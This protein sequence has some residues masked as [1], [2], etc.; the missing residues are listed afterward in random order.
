M[1]IECEQCHTK[2]II[3]DEKIVKNVLR[4]TCQKCGHVITARVEEIPSGEQSGNTLGKWRATSLNTPKRTTIEA[5]AWYYS[6]NGESFGPFT[7]AELIARLQDPD[8][9]EIA[10]RCYIWC[11]T[12]EQWRPILEVEPFS[13][14][15]LMPPPPAPTPVA[16][17]DTI[18]SAQDNL[19]PLFEEKHTPRHCSITPTRPSSPNIQGLRQRLS[20]QSEETKAVSRQYSPFSKPAS[21]P[22]PRQDDVPTHQAIPALDA[23]TAFGH[24]VEEDSPEDRTQVGAPSPFFSFQSLDA[25]SPDIQTEIQPGRPGN[26]NKKPFPTVSSLPAITPKK[27]HGA[28]KNF[29]AFTAPSNPSPGIASIFSE[30]TPSDT[31]QS[32]P[33]IASILK[34]NAKETSPSTPS[35]PRFASLRSISHLSAPAIPASQP[36]PQDCPQNAPGK[37]THTS[38]DLIDFKEDIGDILEGE[39]HAPNAKRDDSVSSWL[40]SQSALQSASSDIDFSESD[41]KLPPDIIGQD[42]HNSDIALKPGNLDDEQSRH[43][44]ETADSHK[45]AP[46][47]PEQDAKDKAD[48]VLTNSKIPALQPIPATDDAHGNSKA[49]SGDDTSDLGDIDLDDTPSLTETGSIDAVN[50]DSPSEK[51]DA[52]GDIDLDDAPQAP[53]NDHSDKQPAVSSA[54]DVGNALD[55]ETQ[56]DAPELAR[57]SHAAPA[58]A[59]HRNALLAEI[60]AAGDMPEIQDESISEKSQLIQLNHFI[61]S[62]KKDKQKRNIRIIAI[63]MV[64]AIAIAVAVALKTQSD[65]QPPSVKPEITSALILQPR[66]RDITSDE[67]N[68]LMPEKD[69]EMID[70]SKKPR[71]PN[72]R[73]QDTAQN[74]ANSSNN[75]ESATGATDGSDGATASSRTKKDGRANVVLQQ[76]NDFADTNAVKGSQIQ[77]PGKSPSTRDRFAIGLR[78]VSMTVQECHRREAKNGG[79]IGVE[80]IYIQLTVNPD[81]SVSA[82]STDSRSNIPDSFAKCLESKKTRW[83]FAPFDGDP[84]NLKQGFVLN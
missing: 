3:P 83:K 13:S 50:L 48:D 71:L 11:K 23:F 66:G 72:R 43:P 16:P 4:L 31:A 73:P 10:P 30:R 82:F 51:M 5:P 35:V 67:I 52:L 58:R 44:G 63:L 69:F 59:S 19:P 81:G 76:A 45:T 80:K 54:E 70:F 84:V 18:H 60:E 29:S 26:A 74:A 7:E 27:D 22:L 77:T 9:H 64:I 40:P 47:N 61:K 75:A 17:T 65:S 15:I 37:S 20:S 24:N 32:S 34:T 55:S 41:F 62:A 6:H 25:I 8:L 78:S 12:F 57:I 1:R 42:G 38:D 56:N 79:M 53:V 28:P 68:R 49:V 39:K 21:H 2:Y 36:A 46:S 33:S 14:A